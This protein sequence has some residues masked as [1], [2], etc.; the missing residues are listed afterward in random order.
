MG[1]SLPL[2]VNQGE[3][4][5]VLEGRGVGNWKKKNE[6]SRNWVGYL[7]QILGK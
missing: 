6:K 2:K 4:V 1:E 7:N 3:R 5:G